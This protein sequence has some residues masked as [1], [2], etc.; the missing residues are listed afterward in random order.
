MAIT[1]IKNSGGGGG[2]SATYTVWLPLNSMNEGAD[3]YT[4]LNPIDAKKVEWSLTASSVNGSIQV[5]LMTRNKQ[6]LWTKSIQAK[7]TGT[8]GEETIDCK[9]CEVVRIKA[10]TACYYSYIRVSS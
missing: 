1:A 6:S 7:T 10:N 8:V 5:T 9:D 4:L 2:A 3:F